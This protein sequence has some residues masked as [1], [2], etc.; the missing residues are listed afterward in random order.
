MK[1]LNFFNGR[2]LLALAISQVS[3]FVA[4]QYHIR[5]NLELTLFGLA[6]AFPLGFSI[7]SAF[8]RR[9]KAL[10][11]FSLFKGGSVALMN[12]F[13]L[14]EDLDEK[15]KAEAATVIGEMNAQLVSQLQNQEGRYALLQKKIDAVLDFIEANRDGL[16][17]RNIL[18][19]VRY[20]KDISE[21]SAYLLSLVRHRTMAGL[22]FYSL[23]FI[24]IF[25]AVQAPIILYR[26]ESI[27][28]HGMIYFLIGLSS[29]MLVTLSNFQKLL[30]YPFDPKGI[31]NIRVEDFKLDAQS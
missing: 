23:L 3:V 17:N 26:L 24:V 4:I 19:M 1:V 20:M 30:E 12:S 31:D 14:S 8:K 18:R 11:Y 5:F 29:L 10:E 13:R 7:Q 6:I 2:T 16:S 21:S 28:N 15:K 25:P 27:T 9:E 22:R